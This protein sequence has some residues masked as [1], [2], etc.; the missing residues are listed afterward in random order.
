MHLALNKLSIEEI[1]TTIQL[2]P[3]QDDVLDLSSNDLVTRLSGT[4]LNHTL[5]NSGEQIRKVYLA[6]NE[7]GYMDNPELITGL[8]GLKPLVQELSLNNNKFYQKTSEEMQEVMAALPEGIQHIDLMDNKFETKDTLELETILLA[9]PNSVHTIRISFTKTIDL[10][11]LRNQHK[12]CELVKHS[13]FNA[14]QESQAAEA[15]EDK[16]NAYQFI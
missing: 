13:M 16:A 5:V 2:I 6:D 7:L 3:A 12:E 1:I 11:A 4:E 9:A 14:K 10:I 8:K 15:E